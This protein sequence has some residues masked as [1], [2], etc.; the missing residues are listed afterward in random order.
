MDPQSLSGLFQIQ[1][2]LKCQTEKHKEVGKTIE[3]EESEKFN[4]VR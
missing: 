2:K 3:K 4:L 1:S